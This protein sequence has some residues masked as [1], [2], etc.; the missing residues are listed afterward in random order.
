[1]GR[2]CRRR[3]GGHRVRDRARR[4]EAAVAQ[5]PF[6][7]VGPPPFAD[8][9]AREVHHQIRS[10]EVRDTDLGQNLDLSETAALDLGQG[11]KLFG[12]V[13]PERFHERHM[14]IAASV[15]Q[16]VLTLRRREAVNCGPTEVEWSVLVRQEME[17][18]EHRAR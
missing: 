9:L 6:A 10:G 11:D 14:R 2:S 8:R 18:E 16:S 13:P 3:C 12:H 7:R 4:D 5:R 17:S 15:E 1:M